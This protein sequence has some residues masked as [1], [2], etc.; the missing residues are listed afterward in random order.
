MST[1]SFALLAADRVEGVAA[2]PWVKVGPFAEGAAVRQV[3]GAGVLDGGAAR[4]ELLM[5]GPFDDPNND[6]IAAP[7]NTVIVLSDFEALTDFAEKAD[8]LFI[9]RAHW[10]RISIADGGDALDTRWWIL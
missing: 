9:T 1:T 10:A 7:D 3:A 5:A 4:V 6:E 2:T 8:G